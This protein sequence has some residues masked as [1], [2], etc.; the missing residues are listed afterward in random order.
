MGEAALAS[1][2][3]LAAA[4]LAASGSGATYFALFRTVVS[5]PAWL[6]LPLSVL[7]LIGYVLL[8]WLGRRRGL[9]L[10]N[11]VGRPARS[12]LWCPAS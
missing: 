1:V 8:L 7:A 5:Y 12:R 2:R 3:S 10:R 11:V 4:D 9:R 6:D